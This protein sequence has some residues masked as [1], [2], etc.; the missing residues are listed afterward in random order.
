M[1]EIKSAQNASRV[2]D[3][4]QTAGI[5]WRDFFTCDMARSE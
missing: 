3:E 1:A 2:L 4:D 5:F